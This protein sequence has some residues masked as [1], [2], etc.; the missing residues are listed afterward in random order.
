MLNMEYQ[1]VVVRPEASIKAFFNRVYAWMAGGLALTAAVAWYVVHNQAL[2]QMILGNTLV[3]LLLIFAEFG[4]VIWLSSSIGK[5]S[6]EI[7]GFAFLAYAAING[8]T[9]SA[10]FAV[11]TGASIF[12]AFA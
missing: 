11:Y 5:M 9:L 6:P 8:L 7:A 10:I 12:M 4:L 1:G 2:Q 3:F